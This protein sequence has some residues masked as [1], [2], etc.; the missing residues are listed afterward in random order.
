MKEVALAARALMILS[1]G[2]LFSLGALHLAY[3]FRGPKLT[4]RDPAIRIGMTQSSVVISKQMTVWRAW[5]G[6][7]VSHSMGAMLF[8]LVFGYLAAAHPE[9]LFRSPF[10]LG[11][12]LATLGGL[13]V[14]SKVYWFAGPLIGTGTA[15]VCYGGER[16]AVAELAPPRCA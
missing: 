9:L 7:N 13:V 8:G 1:A 15:L 5:V 12:G 14:V 4:P 10:L 11:V 3:T 6:F 2:I 16:R